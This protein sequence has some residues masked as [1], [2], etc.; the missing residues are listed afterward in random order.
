M[1]PGHD[2]H[3]EDHSQHEQSRR[4]DAG[5]PADRPVRGRIHDPAPGTDQHQQER[6]EELAEQ[7]APFQPGI[8]ERLRPRG[9]ESE[10]LG[11]GHAGIVRGR[12]A[13]VLA[14]GE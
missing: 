5:S 3:E 10:E 9:L 8:V 14:R 12:Q 11:S 2:A 13:P 4:G 1:R 6:A 7:P